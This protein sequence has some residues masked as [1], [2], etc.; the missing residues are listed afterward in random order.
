MRLGVG[1]SS[2]EVKKRKSNEKICA[3]TEQLKEELHNARLK[4]SELE[5]KINCLDQ[6]KYNAYRDNTYSLLFKV[7]YLS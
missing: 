1:K 6:S 2:S 4:V 7:E 3:Q 5:A